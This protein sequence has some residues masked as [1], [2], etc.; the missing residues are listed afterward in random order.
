MA[1]VVPHVRRA[2][3]IGKAIH[4]RE[5]EAVCFSD[6]LDGL[7]AGMILLDA[8]RSHCPCQPPRPIAILD[9]EDFL[10]AVGGRPRFPAMCR[11]TRA[12][13]DNPHRRR[14]R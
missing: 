6:I 7:S 4:Q 11:S 12:L 14:R 1:L 8:K 3:L 9:A 2:L 13:R 5:A 10:R